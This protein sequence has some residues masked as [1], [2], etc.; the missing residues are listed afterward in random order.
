NK[1]QALFRRIYPENQQEIICDDIIINITGQTVRKA[2]ELI[3][4]TP[5]EFQILSFLY[6]YPKKIYTRDELIVLLWGYDS[7]NDDRIIDA[8]IKNIRKK[9]GYEII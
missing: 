1:I 4:L 7:Q 5:T 9:L 3:D 6:H 2:N 8:H